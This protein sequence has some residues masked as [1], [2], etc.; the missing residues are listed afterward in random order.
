[1]LVIFCLVAFLAA[2]N[3]LATTTCLHP[4]LTPLY[5]KLNLSI[6][7]SNQLLCLCL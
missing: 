1:M 4:L 3:T 7:L 6:S 2:L 5:L